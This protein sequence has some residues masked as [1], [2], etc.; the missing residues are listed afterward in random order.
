MKEALNIDTLDVSLRKQYMEGNITLYQAAREFCRCGWDNFVNTKATKK[1]LIKKG[2]LPD[3]LKSAMI[4]RVD[5]ESYTESIVEEIRKE[6]SAEI[7][8]EGDERNP[9]TSRLFEL[10]KLHSW[11]GHREYQK[12]IDFETEM[13]GEDAF[14]GYLIDPRDV[15]NGL[16][17]VKVFFT[18]LVEQFWMTGF[19]PDDVFSYT[20]TPEPG[21]TFISES[22]ARWLA[23]VLNSCFATCIREKADIYEMAY[24]IVLNNLKTI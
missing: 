11:L 2:E 12:V 1:R 22:D 24:E 15:I 3:P 18:M 14:S 4:C 19:H 9:H 17:D 16:D 5:W 21:K 13:Y 23:D 20:D 10:V 6:R 7:L 8:C